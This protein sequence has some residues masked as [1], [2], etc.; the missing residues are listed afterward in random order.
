MEILQPFWEH[1]IGW[2]LMQLQY[3]MPTYTYNFW[4]FHVCEPNTHTCD[5]LGSILIVTITALGAK[6]WAP[7]EILRFF[8]RFRGVPAWVPNIGTKDDIW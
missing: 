6:E 8:Q 5:G 4:R 1:N 2:M 7:Y 3:Q